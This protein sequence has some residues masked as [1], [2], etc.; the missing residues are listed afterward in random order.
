MTRHPYA[1]RYLVP[2]ARHSTVA[3][4]EKKEMHKYACLIL[5]SGSILKYKDNLDPKS[6]ML[7]S[8][9]SL[10]KVQIVLSLNV[11]LFLDSR[12]DPS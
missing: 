11:M 12:S 4:E 10:K 9:I 7:G 2:A 1:R 5:S 6:S 3:F 8:F